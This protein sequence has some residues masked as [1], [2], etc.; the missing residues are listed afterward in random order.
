MRR[1]WLELAVLLMRTKR[2]RVWLNG[3][4]VATWNGRGERAVIDTVGLSCS[5]AFG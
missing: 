4:S 3:A 2:K 5:G 1:R